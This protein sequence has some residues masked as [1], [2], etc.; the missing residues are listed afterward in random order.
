MNSNK[1]TV[2][3]NYTTEGIS[4]IWIDIYVASRRMHMES[5]KRFIDEINAT[6]LLDRE[7]IKST[8]AKK[9][10]IPVKDIFFA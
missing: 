5:S 3:A 7:T 1:V 10:G 4:V 6:P 8:I 2:Y 9:Y